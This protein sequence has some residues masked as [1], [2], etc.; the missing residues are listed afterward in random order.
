MSVLNLPASSNAVAST[1]EQ[2]STA[3]SPP[4][5]VVDLDGTLSPCDTLWESLVRLAKARPWTTLQLPLW[6]SGG[7]ARFKHEISARTPWKGEALPLN[8]ELV[9]F[10]EQERARG[11]R[12]VLA[13]AANR[14]IAQAIAERTGLFD[15]VIASDETENMKGSK[16]LEMIRSRVGPTFSYAGDS[17]ADIP[18][19][20]GA[21]S[22]VL[23]GTSAATRRTVAASATPIER[24]FSH[25]S[26]TWR[27]W[28]KG[29]RLHQWLKNLLVLVPLFTSF[30]FNHT[31]AAWRALLAFI[32]FSIVASGTYIINDLWD[33]DSDR[34]HPRKRNR[35]FASGR[36]V[37]PRAIAAAALLLISGFAMAAFAGAR[38]TI[39]LAAYLVLTS[40]Y[41]WVLKRKMMADVITLASLYTLRILAGAVA[42]Q[43]TVTTWLFA[44][45]VFIFLS[46]AL[47]KRCAE[48]VSLSHEPVQRNT[49]RGYNVEDLRVLW[50]M[51]VASGMC[52]VVVFGLYVN[53]EAT[54]TRYA[55]PSFIWMAGLLL[56]YWIS[57]LWVKTSRGEMHDDP[58]VY[59]LTDR[60]SQITIALMMA[61][62]LI[63][64]AIPFQLS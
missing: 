34:V 19:W 10:I 44:F 52:S 25:P 48:L 46:L 7:R 47:I 4:P 23:V 11:R 55:S 43:V 6:L 38:F 12:V 33:L 54:Q 61:A 8:T 37:I 57:R 35:P 13:T 59:A 39:L 21:S 27:D 56:I 42:I 3:E 58:I 26:A 22:A 9:A 20:A 50:P 41:S 53:A 51:G 30:S 18:V 36:I 16:K 32:A 17:P 28:M 31:D 2:S 60:N 24:E 62:V 63:S 64:Y 29:L 15:D 45:S 49:G 1:T 5:L 14:S 40:A